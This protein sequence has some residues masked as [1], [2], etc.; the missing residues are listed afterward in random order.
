MSMRQERNIRN[1]SVPLTH[2]V[3]QRGDAKSE[4]P[5]YR[6][7]RRTVIS[8]DVRTYA[9]CNRHIRHSTSVLSDYSLWGELC[10]KRRQLA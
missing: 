2:E 4:V 8:A 1:M 9:R 3:G 5:Y 7:R 6:Q 10:G